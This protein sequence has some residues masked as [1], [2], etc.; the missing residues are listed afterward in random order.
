MSVTR[1]PTLLKILDILTLLIVP[2]VLILV[3]FFTP[4]EA[5]MG[6]VQKVFYFHK[7]L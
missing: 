2:A 4:V 7:V 6:P 5:V 1:K 3:W